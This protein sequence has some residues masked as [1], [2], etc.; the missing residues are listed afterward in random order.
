M[1]VPR[2]M[3]FPTSLL[4]KPIGERNFSALVEVWK[5]ILGLVNSAKGKHLG[6]TWS[7]QQKWMR[8]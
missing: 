8:W 1:G 4:A 7:L 3:E 2:F 6:I 5:A